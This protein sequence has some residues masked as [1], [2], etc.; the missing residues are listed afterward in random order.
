[1]KRVIVVAVVAALALGACTKDTTNRSSIRLVDPGRCTPIDIAAAPEIAP[2]VTW[3]AG[4]FNDSPPRIGRA[5]MFDRRACRRS[6]RQRPLNNSSA[7]GPTP[8]DYGPAPAV[9]VPSSSAWTALVNQRLA[10]RGN[11]PSRRAGRRS[12]ARRW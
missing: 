2:V 12:R 8:T 1:M 11:R 7:A 4:K 3:V 5:G 9:W 6:S 10:A